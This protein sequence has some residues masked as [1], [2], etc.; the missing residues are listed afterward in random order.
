MIELVHCFQ[1]AARALINLSEDHLYLTCRS[2]L[3][4]RLSALLPFCLLLLCNLV[5][6]SFLAS[7]SLSL[8][9]SSPSSGVCMRSRLSVA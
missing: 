9:L 1:S 4:V 8:P 6:F 3:S 7:F 5:S 2:Y